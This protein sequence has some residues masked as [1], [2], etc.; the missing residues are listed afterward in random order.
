MSDNMLDSSSY[1]QIGQSNILSAAEMLD[2]LDHSS[3]LLNDLLPNQIL[4]ANP[5]MVG[6]LRFSQESWINFRQPYVQSSQVFDGNSFSN[7]GS[8]SGFHTTDFQANSHATLTFDEINPHLHMDAV[9]FDTDQTSGAIEY[10]SEHHEDIKVNFL[11]SPIVRSKSSVS[12]SPFDPIPSTRA[13]SATYPFI[14]PLSESQIATIHS[15][16]TPIV[17][18]TSNAQDQHILGQ[19]IRKN[20][21][22]NEEYMDIAPFVTLPQHEAAKRLNIPSSTLSKKWKDATVN[23]KWPYRTLAKIDKEIATIMHNVH[24]NSS[25]TVDPQVEHQLTH[26]LQV[27]QAEIRPV[28]VRM[29]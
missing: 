24:R 27:R 3:S 17:P 21:D 23:R 6:S 18:S 7:Q 13:R 14:S 10:S 15:T 22:I 29:T 28:L 9:K 26:L 19:I 2:V 11:R 12:I 1:L 20:M 25:G 16:S 8:F 4:D 5:N